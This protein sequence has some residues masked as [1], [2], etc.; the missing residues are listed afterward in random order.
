MKFLE[1]GKVV[2]THGVHGDVRLE[3]WCDTPEF[4][5]GFRTLYWGEKPLTVEQ[6]RPHKHFLLVKFQGIDDV[7]SAQ[8]LKNQVLLLD[9]TGVTLPE[10]RHFVSDLIGLRVV[11]EQSAEIGRLADILPMPAHDVYVVRGE[12]E[13]MI[14][15]RP[16]F[17]L[18]IDLEAGAI[19]VRLIE[20]M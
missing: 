13:H 19:T 9:R 12:T 17:V 2:N 14:P 11:D 1:A 3:P 18:G 20:G 10:G 8:R 4:L 16:E 5:M 7:E 15:A 6:A